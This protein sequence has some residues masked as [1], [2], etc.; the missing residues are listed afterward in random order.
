MNFIAHV[1][2]EDGREQMLRDHLVEVKELGEKFGEPL[3]LSYTIGLA[4]LL[5]DIGKYTVEFQTYLNEAV[6]NPDCP[7][8]KGSVVHSRAGGKLLYDLLHNGK[9]GSLAKGLVAEI[10]G[11][12]IISHHAYINDFIRP[13]DLDTPYRN[14]VVEKEVNEYHDLK[15][16]FFRDVMKEEELTEYIKKAI[17]E[18]DEIINDTPQ[19]EVY[20]TMSYVTK[21]VYS[22]LIDADRTNTRDFEQNLKKTAPPSMNVYYNRLTTHLQQFENPHNPINKLRNEMSEICDEFAEKPSGIYTLSIPT[23]GGKTLASLRYALKHASLYSKERIFFIVPFTTIIEQNAEEVRSILQEYSYILEHH[24]NVVTHDSEEED[25]GAL[26]AHQKLKIAEENWDTPIVFTTMVQYLNAIYHRKSSSA[27]RLHNLSNSVLIFDEVQKVPSDCVSLFNLSVNYLCHYANSSAILCTA[28]QPSLEYV[29]NKLKIQEDAEIIPHIEKISRK[30]ERVDVV[31]CATDGQMNNDDLKNFILDKKDKEASVLI[32][33]NTK[34][35]VKDLY[36]KMKESTSYDIYHLSTAMCAEHRR[37][38]IDKINEKVKSGQDMI[39]ISTQLVEAGVDLDFDCVIRSAAGLDSIAQAAGRCNRNGKAEKKNVY[40]I[41]HSEESLSKLKEMKIGKNIS[42]RLMKDI[43]KDPAKN[44]L[45]P[46]VMKRYFREFY[47]EV[48]NRLDYPIPN[49]TDE[50]MINWLSDNRITVTNYVQR[51]DSPDFILR[52]S[53]RS[54]AEKFQ[55]I[56]DLTTSVI[57][58]YCKEGKDVIATLNDGQTI[59]ELSDFLKKAQKFSV[60][61][62]PHELQTLQKKNGVRGYIDGS[63]KVLVEGFY[64]DEF[65]LAISGEVGSGGLIY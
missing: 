51:N 5:H 17:I 32:I 50:T 18:I 36:H 54:A 47:Q 6:N 20:S 3:H 48:Q 62:F 24:S 11:N 15:Q 7:P 64:D 13:S 59:E 29:H 42:L 2:E 53:I 19:E 61:V 28:T 44:I 25:E 35:V 58:P 1:R 63:V 14:S 4:G 10:V 26:D 49:T 9:P 40:V 39:C 30:F 33:L 46:Y 34:Q 27:R 21:M 55:V 31:D 56:P 60:N 23:G 43:K 45:E 12:A 37:N 22:S 16:R 41:N 8:K 52:N 38:F 57:V 65:G